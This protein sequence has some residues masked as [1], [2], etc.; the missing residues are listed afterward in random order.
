ML[1]SQYDCDCVLDPRQM[2][3]PCN[4]PPEPKLAQPSG[5]LGQTL[6]CISCQGYLRLLGELLKSPWD[7]LNLS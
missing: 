5:P 1:H 7:G 2:Q 6:T 4:F 3:K